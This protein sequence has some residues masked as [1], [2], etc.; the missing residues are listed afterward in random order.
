[1]EDKYGTIQTK[2]TILV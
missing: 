1:M 2:M